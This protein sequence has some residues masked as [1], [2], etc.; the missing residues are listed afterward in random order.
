MKQS[1]RTFLNAAIILTG[2]LSV[3]PLLQSAGILNKGADRGGEGTSV[4]AD[5]IASTAPT[6]SWIPHWFPK[7]PL[8]P[9]PTGGVIRVGTAEELLT[10]VDHIQPGGTI[11][12]TEGHYRL[13]RV[14]I[15]QGK[16][17]ITLRSASGDPARTILSGQ[18]WDS[19]A[20]GDDI[21]HIARCEGVTIADLSFTDCRSY[22]IK[23]EAENA[24]K[25]I[26]IYNCRFRDI[27]VRAIKG[28]AG[29]DPNVRAVK[30]S[31]RYCT[32]ENT[33]VPPADWLFG[34]DYI[35]AI[36]MMAL[37]DW[38]FSDNVFRN[39]RGRNGGG[40]AAI[41]VWVRSRGVVVERNFILDCDRG[42]AF[43]NPG[44]STA[45]LA[46]EQLVYVADGVI[47]NNFI[48]GGPDC[49]I[50]LWYTDRT[51]VQ[52]NTI[53]RPERNWRRG[54][55][56]GTGTTQTEVVNNLV[57]GEILLEGGEAHLRTNLTGKLEPYFEDPASGNLTLT[58]AAARAI[59]QGVPLPDVTEDI[60]RRA[61]GQRPD[62]GAWE[63]EAGDPSA[64][65]A[66]PATSP[67]N[68]SVR[69]TV[70]ETP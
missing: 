33:K 34:G 27:G 6:S 37:E 29:Q 70:P 8:L 63:F 4:S 26:H 66:A 51:K 19:Q 16:K 32:F 28:S 15:L 42:V 50:E 10:A 49:G 35:A 48:A 65:G 7:A 1:S 39:I 52:H 13:P 64:A 40:R 25:D 60:R 30:G 18:G 54:I 57:H 43:G 62:L 21:L 3:M 56:I 24:P 22:G 2:S 46:G 9:P 36:D 31:V 5:E 11:L 20:R 14:M 61:R 17:G 53:W 59:D 68:A 58:P 38:T 23:V 45:N 55:R 41:F 44:Q 69:Y 67:A 47:R 12:L